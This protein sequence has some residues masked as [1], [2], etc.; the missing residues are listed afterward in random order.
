MGRKHKD[1]YK[2]TECCTQFDRAKHYVEHMKTLHQVTVTVPDV[3]DKLVQM[4]NEDMRYTKKLTA[5]RAVNKL[6]REGMDTADVAFLSSSVGPWKCADCDEEFPTSRAHRIHLRHHSNGGVFIKTLK[7]V[8]PLELLKEEKVVELVHGCDECEKRFATAFALNAHKKFKHK[9]EE[10][11]ELSRKRKAEKLKYEVECDICDFVSP[12]RDYVEHHV[13][14]THKPEFFCRHCHR[15]L[16]S[17]NYFIYHLHEHHP[18]SIKAQQSAHKCNEC[19]KSFRSE[20]ILNT[21]K[22][23]KHRP[24][25]VVPPNYC[26]PC[27]VSYK[28]PVWLEQHKANYYHM[29]LQTFLDNKLTSNLSTPELSTLKPAVVILPHPSA[30]P[31]EG[32][33]TRFKVKNEPV[34]IAALKV[35]AVKVLEDNQEESPEVED[36]AFDGDPFERMMKQ[37]LNVSFE[38][39]EKRIRLSTPTPAAAENPSNAYDDDKLEYLQYLQTHDDGY[40][41][42]IC[43]KIKAVRKYMLH[44]LKQHKEVPTYTCTRCP[45]KFVFKKKFEKHLLFHDTQNDKEYEREKMIVDVEHPKFQETTKQAPNEIKCGICQLTF[46]LTIMLN[47][48]NSTWHGDDNADKK[49]TMSEQKARKDEPKLEVAVIKLL[50][51]KHCQEA[52]IKPKGLIEHLKEKHNSESIDTPMELEQSQSTA[53]AEPNKS[54]LFTCDKCKIHYNEKKFLENHQKHFCIHREKGEPV[55]NEQ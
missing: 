42:G 20:D 53:Q 25:F 3:N 4:S 54:E 12:R 48:H 28:D 10:T 24:D 34:D 1:D 45:E 31:V 6:Q 37:K 52:F 39:P 17:Y 36:D 35:E 44:H 33:V 18:K 5:I 15:T 41:C 21:H 23:H 50:K 38:P 13:R 40:K 46:K 26:Q 16:S 47:R 32:P 11:A 55:M 22:T 9:S 19:G 30:S 2:C 27:G 51:C 14:Q 43:G 8:K 49:M 29:G 7:D